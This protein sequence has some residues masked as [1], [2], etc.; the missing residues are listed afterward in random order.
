MNI[1]EVKQVTAGG[2]DF[3]VKYSNRAFA[4]YMDA[5][6]KNPESYD[7]KIQYFY[8]L[9]KIGAK[10]KGLDFNYSFEEFSE[11]IDPDPNAVANFYNVV[12]SFFGEVG[13]EKKPKKSSK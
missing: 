7:V 11:V 4:A 8:D 9:S 5:M 13:D 2:V 6:S 12:S 3:F 1:G 10:A